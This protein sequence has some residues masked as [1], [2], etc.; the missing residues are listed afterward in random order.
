MNLLKMG[1]IITALMVI[2]AVSNLSVM[3]NPMPGD[4]P[5]DSESNDFWF[6]FLLGV[7]VGSAVTLIVDALITS[8]QS[9]SFE[10]EDIEFTLKPGNVISVNADYHL[11]NESG[12]PDTLRIVYP[13]PN[14]DYLQPA[15]CVILDRV[16]QGKSYPL[17][18]ENNDGDW[19][20]DFVLEAQATTTL[21]IEYDQQ[22][23][24]NCFKYLLTTGNG[25]GKRIKQA[26]F[27]IKIPTGCTL[28]SLS[29]THGIL[30]V[31]DDYTVYQIEERDFKPEKELVFSW[32]E[33]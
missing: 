32:I 5:R 8:S 21:H 26:N 18:F 9:V 29:Y 10:S 23:T 16:Y 25:W 20:F 30:N 14:D 24:E 28:D 15:E 2:V 4:P 13:F 31:G 22:S 7:A 11:F 1:R 17:S 33:D 6:Y 3:A 27:K 19:Y 12:E